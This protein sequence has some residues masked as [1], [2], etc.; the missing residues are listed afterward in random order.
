[1]G[2]DRNSH[3]LAPWLT[4]ELSEFLLTP[5]ASVYI[6]FVVHMWELGWGLFSF[7]LISLFV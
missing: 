1:M 7:L 4:T 3:I 5:K 2:G 6:G